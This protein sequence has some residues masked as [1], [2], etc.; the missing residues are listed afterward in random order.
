M[1][2]C[3]HLGRQ[4][5]EEERNEPLPILECDEHYQQLLT[6]HRDL[7]GELAT[8][9]TSGHLFERNRA[10]VIIPCPNLPQS[11]AFYFCCR[12]GE[13]IHL[14]SDD[15]ISEADLASHWHLVE[16]ADYEEVCAFVGFS[17]FKLTHYKAMDT[18]NVVDGTWVR[19]WKLDKDQG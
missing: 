6:E 14:T 2:E 15:A 9:S 13:H 8:A 7:L 4:S 10:D 19:K 5:K 3:D 1:D 11:Q 16:S 12:T 17:C 18:N